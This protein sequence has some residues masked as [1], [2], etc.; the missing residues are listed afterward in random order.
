[1]KRST[2]LRALE[3][4]I[5]RAKEQGFSSKT[6]AEVIFEEIEDAGMSPPGNSQGLG[7][8]PPEWDAE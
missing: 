8:S 3:A 6:I 1:M 4:V 2:M 7:Y 5:D